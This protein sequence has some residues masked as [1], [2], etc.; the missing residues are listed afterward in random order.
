MTSEPEIETGFREGTY[1]CQDDLALYW[2]DYG[3]PSSPRVPV[4]CLGGL[5]R[6]S[7]RTG[8]RGEDGSP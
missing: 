8:T 7:Q 1:R 5:T 3:D 6:N 2:R 4:L